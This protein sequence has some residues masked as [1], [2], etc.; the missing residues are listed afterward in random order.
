MLHILLKFQHIY[1]NHVLAV[2]VRHHTIGIY[3]HLTLIQLVFSFLFLN[4]VYS[5]L[6]ALHHSNNSINVLDG[7]NFYN[8]LNYNL[9]FIVQFFFTLLFH[10]I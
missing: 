8:N 5:L 4:I 6:N 7:L 2:E 3:K 1:F 10:F 9:S